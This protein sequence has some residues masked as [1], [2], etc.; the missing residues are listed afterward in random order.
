MTRVIRVMPNTP[1]LV[2]CS[3]SAFSPGS[4]ATAQDC[5]LVKRLFSSIGYCVQVPER[6][7]DAVTGLSGSGPAYVSFCSV[8]GNLQIII[9]EA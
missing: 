7:L 4:S 3:A 8:L 1:A 2:Q 6:Q 5:E 9:N